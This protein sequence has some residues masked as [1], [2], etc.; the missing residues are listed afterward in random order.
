[1]VRRRAPLPRAPDLQPSI[2]EAP[3]I[4]ELVLATSTLVGAGLPPQLLSDLTARLDGYLQVRR[5]AARTVPAL[6]VTNGRAATIAASDALAAAIAGARPR[7]LP[8]E[9]FTPEI[10]AAI[11]AAVAAGC[12]RRFDLLRMTV[13]DDIEAPLP[14]PAVNGRWPI[15]A[16]LPTM[17]PDLLGALP[18][19]PPELE[20]RFVNGALVLRDID[21]NLIVDVLRDVIPPSGEIAPAV[22]AAGGVPA[23]PVALLAALEASR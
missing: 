16:P 12:D 4:T 19:L 1:M 13:E 22:P 21:A 15:G 5:V 3:V 17:P 9:I 2:E 10:A 7:A 11:R 23:A 6:T 18:P 8:G 20:Y 14:T